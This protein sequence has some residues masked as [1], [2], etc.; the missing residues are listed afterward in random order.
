MPKYVVALQLW[1][2]Q[3]WVAGARV[4]AGISLVCEVVHDLSVATSVDGKDGTAKTTIGGSH[5]VVDFVPVVA[6]ATVPSVAVVAMASALLV[7]CLLLLLLLVWLLCLLVLLMQ[8][9]LPLLLLLLLSLFHPPL[10][11]CFC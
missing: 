7:F 4:V 2:E 11:F 6:V 3:V 8:A 5:V 1:L 9:L 10:L